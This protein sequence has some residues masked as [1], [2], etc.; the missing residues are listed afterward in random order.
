MYKAPREAGIAENSGDQPASYLMRSARRPK[1]SFTY[2]SFT[3]VCCHSSFQAVRQ[4]GARSGPWRFGKADL[5]RLSWANLCCVA[6]LATTQA[7][8]FLAYMISTVSSGSND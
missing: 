1:A 8:V 2:P 7:D 5:Q 6:F 4:L 3:S